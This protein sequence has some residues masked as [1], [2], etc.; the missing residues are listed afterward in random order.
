MSFSGLNHLAIVAAAAASF[1]F[2]GVWYGV[3]SEKWMLAAGLKLEDIQ[4]PKGGASMFPYA[5]AF[6]AQWVMALVLAG[7]LGHLGAGQVTLSNGLI[8][9][10]L[11]WAGFVMTT[12]AVNHSFQMQ[13]RLLTLIDGG[14]WLGV[15]L[16]QG[17]IIGAM[18]IA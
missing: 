12:L 4:K 5:L 11:V 6:I 2:G 10:L 17:G 14:H 9:G 15:L 13:S 1:L 16:L 18:G 3:W 8:T 7:I